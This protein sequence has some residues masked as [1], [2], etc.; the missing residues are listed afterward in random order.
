LSAAAVV[1]AAVPQERTSRVYPD[2]HPRKRSMIRQAGAAGAF[3]IGAAATAAARPPFF[4]TRKLN[5]AGR[6][7]AQLAEEVHLVVVEA[8]RRDL[9]GFDDCNVA[10][11]DPYPL[12]GGGQALT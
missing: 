4:G 5:S 2:R 10:P 7:Q 3:T 8:V 9:P 12:A 1:M 6:K 11:S